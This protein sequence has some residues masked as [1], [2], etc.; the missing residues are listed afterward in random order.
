M[1]PLL[2]EADLLNAV[3]CN[4]R[5]KDNPA[6]VYQVAQMLIKVIE[7]LRA[8]QPCEV[9]EY[10]RPT[11]LM[12]CLSLGTAS[13][14]SHLIDVALRFGDVRTIQPPSQKSGAQGNFRYHY[15]DILKALKKSKK[16]QIPQ[17]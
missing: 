17:L 3:D 10:V 15:G 13:Q 14:A 8:A 2:K 1:K 11:D 9:P 6:T 16:S 12:R 7:V 4:N 5:Y